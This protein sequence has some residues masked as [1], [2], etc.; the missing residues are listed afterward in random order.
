MAIRRK[1]GR[2]HSAELFGMMLVNAGIASV[3]LLV[4]FG[5]FGTRHILLPVSLQSAQ[6]ADL[7]GSLFKWLC[8]GL[9]LP[10]SGIL[11]GCLW[12][13]LILTG[14]RQGVNW[15]AGMLYGV[16]IALANALLCGAMAGAMLGN[17]LIGL[18]FA[19]V[20]ILLSG[21]FL[22]ATATFGVFMGLL[23]ALGA[24]RWIAKHSRKD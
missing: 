9:L 2:P 13:W 6:I 21:S 10:G 22:F 11:Y 19:L 17:S 8:Y 12:F 7:T 24:S 23:N 16:G 3:V 5:I 20:N 4:V 15:S 1:Y 18:V 14:R